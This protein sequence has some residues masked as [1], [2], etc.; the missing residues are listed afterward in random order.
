VVG[1]TFVVRSSSPESTQEIGRAVA[2]ICRAG[3]VI[4]LVGDIGTGK[5][6]LTQGIADGL[7]VGVPV[8]SPT[9]VLVRQY[10]GDELDLTHVDLYRLESEAEARSLDLDECLYDSDGVTV[11]EWADRFTSVLPEQ[12]LMLTIQYDGLEQRS[13]NISGVGARGRAMAEELWASL[14]RSQ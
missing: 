4:A 8:T 6:T 2:A 1:P 14:D 10:A 7:G 11:L 13:I 5:T 3:D 9:F 12:Y